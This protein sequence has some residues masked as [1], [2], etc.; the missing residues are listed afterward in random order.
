M[1]TTIDLPAELMQ[2]AKIAAVERGISLKDLFTKALAHEIG[3]TMRG[4]K[5]GR[6]GFPLIGAPDAE[7]QVDVTNAD[8]AAAFEAEDIEKYAQ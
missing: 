4:R 2:A 5:G 8:I 1:R 6:V 7:P 3:A